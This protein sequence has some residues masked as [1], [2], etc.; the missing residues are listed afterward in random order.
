MRNEYELVS[1][2][3]FQHLNVFLVYLLSRTPHIHRDLEIGL[4]L[5]G[6]VSVKLGDRSW[7]LEKNDLYLINSMDAHEF[8]S[9]GDGT[10]VL[11]IQISPKLL[12]PFLPDAAML[13]Y[14]TDP[15]LQKALP[16]EDYAFALG[17]CLELAYQYYK[18]PKN[19][20]LCC[21]HLI[22]SLLYRMQLRLPMQTISK[23][24]YAPMKRRTDR[25]ISVTDYIDQNFQRKLL[26]QEIADRQHLTLTYLSGLF[27]ETLGL[28]FQDYLKE[29]R[30]ECACQQL[31]GTD[32]TILEI[33]LE[34]G[35]SDVRY[36]NRLFR[37]KLGRSP[38]EYREGLS[39]RSGPFVNTSFTSAQ[40]FL[41]EADTL[42]ILTAL[43]TSQEFSR[44]KF[45]E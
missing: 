14:D 12:E 36:M 4:I 41:T 22:I 1:H 35:F 23:Q 43:R 9:E 42:S 29:K 30:F 11:A 15:L 13:R 27:K 7:R 37:E 45:S 40:Q 32:K 18:K 39:K 25:L 28:S 34:S 20:E 2:A 21:F 24:D 8:I 44:G 26:L 38:R 19:Y 16:S 17:S 10:L 31:A 5:E 6:A 33:S 3:Q